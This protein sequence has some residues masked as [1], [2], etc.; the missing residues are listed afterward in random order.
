MNRIFTLDWLKLGIGFKGAHFGITLGQFG[1]SN[2]LNP[3][4]IFHIEEQCAEF[5][6][7][8][9]QKIAIIFILM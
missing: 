4:N 3:F 5:N 7:P 9:K 6:R 1:L 2:E 8:I